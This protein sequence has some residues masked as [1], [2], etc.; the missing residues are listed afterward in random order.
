MG[1]KVRDYSKLALDIIGAVGGAKNI[2]T[3]ARCAT[4]LRFVLKEVPADATEKISA[5]PGVITVVEKGGQYQVVIG[6]HVGEVYDVVARELHLDDKQGELSEEKR[7][8]VNRMIA[9]ISAVI[10][11]FV[12]VLAAAG[13]IQGCLIVVKQ[14]APDVV[15]NGTYLLMNMISWVPFTF[16]PVLIAVSAAKHFQCN[17]YIALTCCCALLSPSWTALAARIADGETIRFLFF[18]MTRT[19]YSSTVLPPL[20]LVLALS[21]LER[22]LQKHLPDM[23]K[24]L[25][26]PFLCLAIMVPATILIIGP[27]SEGVTLALANG[28]NV[29]YEAVPVL[30]AL[31][32]GALWQVLVIFGVHW[33]FT[34][35][36]LANFEVFGYDTLQVFKTF[37]V[38]AQAAAC[39]GV[40]VK[41]RNKEFKNVAFSSGLTGVFGITEPAIYGVTLRLK[42]PFICACIAGGVAS[43]VASFFG[44]KY[45][46]YA[47]LPGVL[48]TVNAIS[49]EN[50]NSFV[51]LIVGCV[52]AII[53]AFVLVQIV[54]F[55]DPASPESD[56]Q[57]DSKTEKSAVSTSKEAA[58]NLPEEIAIYSPLNGTISALSAVNDP[59]FS[60]EILGKGV[61]IFPTEG[62]LYAPVDGVISCLFETKHAIGITTPEGVE[63]LIHIGLETVALGGKYFTEKVKAGDSIKKGDLLLEFDLDAIKKDYDMITPVLIANTADF[64]S[65]TPVETIGTI[66]AGEKI[67][68]IR[69]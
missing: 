34:P 35:V 64:V 16:L 32:V 11:P 58:A 42:K 59:T 65:V 36:T 55:T 47:G 46:V 8:L 28:Y 61:A 6:P 12:Y 18:N 38:V 57:N 54:G 50:P 29:L 9:A 5:M 21:Y 40:Y 24:P 22:F 69:S 27:I 67:I 56:R 66:K 52:I 41:S 49:E 10:T 63:L 15:T 33:G 4:R 60:Q 43:A 17:V 45:Y 23:I 62:K 14:F 44:S 19:T 20:F 51:G 37:A 39:F 31:I 53:G 26:T 3:A 7:S 2:N 48:T 30:A 13:L 68:T 25:A 1:S